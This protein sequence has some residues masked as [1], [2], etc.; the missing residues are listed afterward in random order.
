MKST[1]CCHAISTIGVS[2][3]G[4]VQKVS[5]NCATYSPALASKY[6][7][8]SAPVLRS[9]TWRSIVFFIHEPTTCVP[10][11]TSS[12]YCCALLN[13]SPT[14]SKGCSGKVF[15]AP[16]PRLSAGATPRCKRVERARRLTSPA[17]DLAVD[18]HHL[19]GFREDAALVGTFV[20]QNRGLAV[21][22][23][24]LIQNLHAN[25]RAAT[26]TDYPSGREITEDECAADGGRSRV[27]GH[28][29]RE[30]DREAEQRAF[31]A[32]VVLD[33]V[34][35]L[36]AGNLGLVQRDD[37]LAV[38]QELRVRVV[39]LTQSA[40]QSQNVVDG[41]RSGRLSDATFEI[42]ERRRGT[43]RTTHNELHFFQSDNHA[44][45]FS[46]HEVLQ[47]F[48]VLQQ[49]PRH[50]DLVAILISTQSGVSERRNVR[51]ECV[52]SRVG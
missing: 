30:R 18:G 12:M 10:S 32:G 26:I 43:V 6:K 11:R 42:A 24:N 37:G 47:R 31:A 29:G 45:E 20:A 9:E 28:L 35:E 25:T 50:V 49:F 41:Q 27:D 33:I 22:G 8:R 3:F 19:R 38:S 40:R 15:E 16:S 7:P 36:R 46:R 5:I 1:A 48:P 21:G 2:W 4:G 44:V 13:K 23:E 39:R 14:P 52:S 34:L 51:R 17:S